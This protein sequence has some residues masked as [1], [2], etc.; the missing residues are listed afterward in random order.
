M[1]NFLSL[2]T[3]VKNHLLINLF[4]LERNG[5]REWLPCQAGEGMVINH[6]TQANMERVTP[7][8]LREPPLLFLFLYAP[9]RPGCGL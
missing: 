4:I 5:P 7:R 2:E 8:L 3:I 6:P 9:R 1:G